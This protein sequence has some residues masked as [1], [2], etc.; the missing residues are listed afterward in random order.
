LA[1]AKVILPEGAVVADGVTA[2][3]AREAERAPGAAAEAGAADAGSADVAALAP[4]Q[5]VPM[6][7]RAAGTSTAH[8]PDDLM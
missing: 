8:L 1:T 6:R 4:E 7:N 5:A 2:H 3:C